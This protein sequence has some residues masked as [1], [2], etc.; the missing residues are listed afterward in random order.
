MDLGFQTCGCLYDLHEYPSGQQPTS[1]KGAYDL[2]DYPAG[3]QPASYNLG[4]VRLDSIQSGQP[5]IGWPVTA[6]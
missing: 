1:Y 5:P 4:L 6:A 2:H 3:Q